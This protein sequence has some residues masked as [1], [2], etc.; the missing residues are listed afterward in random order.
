M[1]T[2]IEILSS[3]VDRQETNSFAAKWHGYESGD[4]SIL[5]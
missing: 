4:D 2:Y 3:S 1:S 5:P